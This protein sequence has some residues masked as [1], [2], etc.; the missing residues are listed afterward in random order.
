MNLEVVILTGGQGKRMHSA[1][2]KVL[3]PLAGTALLQR[4]VENVRRL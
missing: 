4:V 3:H 1:I 2:P